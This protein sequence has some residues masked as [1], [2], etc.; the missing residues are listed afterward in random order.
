MGEQTEWPASV[1]LLLAVLC[2]VPLILSLAWRLRPVFWIS[3]LLAF[4]LVPVAVVA[5]VA[6]AGQCSS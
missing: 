3:A 5:V 4:L 6:S 1:A 2:V